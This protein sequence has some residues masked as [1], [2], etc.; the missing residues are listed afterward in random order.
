MTRHCQ[1]GANVVVSSNGT[2]LA[3]LTSSAI[4]QMLSLIELRF[5]DWRCTQM[6][7]IISACSATSFGINSDYRLKVTTLTMVGDG[8]CCV[9]QLLPKRLIQDYS[10]M[11]MKQLKASLLMKR[12]LD[13]YRRNSHCEST[14]K[15][16]MMAKLLCNVRIASSWSASADSLHHN[17]SNCQAIET[18]EQR[19]SDAGIA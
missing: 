2:D 14:T 7:K 17:V 13:L 18:L 16:I 3:D 15:S 6:R 10:A 4:I 11:Q 9:K 8:I 19:L 5:R 12:K 1:I